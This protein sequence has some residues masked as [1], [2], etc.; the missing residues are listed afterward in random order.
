MREQYQG[1][2]FKYI[3]ILNSQDEICEIVGK[4][5]IETLRTL[6]VMLDVLPYFV[7]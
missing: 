3:Q 5:L 2:G 6:L 4:S 1:S 7:D